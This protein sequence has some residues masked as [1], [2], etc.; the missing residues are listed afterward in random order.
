MSNSTHS[1]WFQGVD[2]THFSKIWRIDLGDYKRT[3]DVTTQTSDWYHYYK[4]SR[5]YGTNDRIIHY[6]RI[7]EYLFMDTLFTMKIVRKFSRGPTCC[8]LFVTYKVCVYV[9]P[10]KSKSEFL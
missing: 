10:M 4:L 1:K 5:N 6:K 7:I 2:P 8:H 9:L 3:L